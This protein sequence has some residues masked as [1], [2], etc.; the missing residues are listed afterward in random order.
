[1]KQA[2][3]II[4]AAMLGH[5]AMAAPPQRPPDI[6]TRNAVPASQAGKMPKTGERYRTLEQQMERARPAVESAKGQSEALSAQAAQLR[7]Q[8]IE[9]AARVQNLEIEKADIERKVASLAGQE[10]SMSAAFVRGRNRLSRLL[11]VLERLQTDL[12]PAV[13]LEPAD[14]LKASR[15]AMV[16]GSW[17]PQIYGAAAALSQQLK[18]LQKT[19]TALLVQ[20]RESA[21]SAARLIEARA[22]LGRMVAAKEMA[23]SGAAAAWQA[24]QAK[25][26]AI[27]AEASDL[28]A[29]LD[30]VSVL[31]GG[32]Q[33]DQVLVI[34]SGGVPTQVNLKPGAL[35]RPVVGPVLQGGS[36][37]EQ[38]PGVEFL[39]GASASVVAPAD[40]QV[41]FAGPYHKSGQVLILKAAGGYDLVLAGL[42]RIEVRPGDRL[43]A[44][45]PV[46][47]MPRRNGAKLYFELRRN[48]K[49]LSPM[50]WLGLNLR[51]KKT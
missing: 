44:G 20:R 45:E 28:R 41:L 42:G 6:D 39:T 32:Q 27:A 17:L 15:G 16:L 25:F 37:G 8:L 35:A 10:K 2:F 43:L 47:W 1:M 18:A 46:G 19:R 11:A 40:S 9:A 7:E 14:A 34:S 49:G 51:K 33:P 26:N 31:R 48:G 21:A 50:S 13:A 36:G 3:P 30:R 29:L 12:P 5:G 22:R 38:M 23:A 4:V 24:L